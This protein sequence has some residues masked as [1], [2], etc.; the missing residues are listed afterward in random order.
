[1]TPTLD[2]REEFVV[3]ARELIPLAQ[4]VGRSWM[5]YDLDC[6]ITGEESLLRED[7]DA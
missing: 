5:A 7:E 3:V 6:A 2:Q 4:A 1:M